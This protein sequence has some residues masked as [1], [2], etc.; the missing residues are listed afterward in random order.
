MKITYL[1]DRKKC[2]RC[3]DEWCT[4]TSDIAHAV[5]FIVFRDCEG[6]IVGATEAVKEEEAERIG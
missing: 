5:N 1:C 2:E 3:N 4:H 6:E